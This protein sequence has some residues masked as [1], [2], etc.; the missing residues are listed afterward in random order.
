[1]SQLGKLFPNIFFFFEKAL[2]KVKTNDQQPSFNIYF[3]RPR[4]G[5][6][7]KTN[8]ITFQ[9]VDSEISSILIFIKG[10]GISFSTTFCV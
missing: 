5:Q 2:Y 6:T 10:S 3:G 7:I 4:L 1:M 9:T 8:F